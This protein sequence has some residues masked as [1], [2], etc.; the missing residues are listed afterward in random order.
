MMIHVFG[1]L[2]I[3]ICSGQLSSEQRAGLLERHN[4]YRRQE[5]QNNL[6]SG[7]IEM[8]WDYD[9]ETVAQTFA[10]QGT[11]AG[12][13]SNRTNHYEQLIG[14]NVNGVGEN[15]FSGPPTG[16]SG[17]MPE[18][19]VHAWVDFKWPAAWT[20]QPADCSERE[21]FYGECAGMTG[22][23]TQVLWEGSY[24]VGCG[25]T[26]TH[27]TTC[28]YFPPGNFNNLP[29]STSGPACA[30]CPSSHQNCPDSLCTMA[31]PTPSPTPSPTPPTSPLPPSVS[32][33]PS[34]ISSC[35]YS[36]IDWSTN[37]C[38]GGY[39]RTCDSRCF[40]PLNVI[41]SYY[42]PD[43]F[44]SQGHYDYLKAFGV[45]LNCPRFCCGL[46]W[47]SDP[48]GSDTAAL[49]GGEQEKKQLMRKVEPVY[50]ESESSAKNLCVYWSSFF[51]L[52]SVSCIFL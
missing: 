30:T 6:G 26:S 50:I 43:A 37:Q 24:K 1:F 23:F 21:A 45:N 22:H 32:P 20:G 10:N 9:L 38:P 27:G 19:A 4:F 48:C 13:N 16:G 14:E 18:D 8:E 36:T 25:Y 41:Q 52:L 11:F 44:G 3:R 47:E 28:N 51:M 33:T 40:S 29:H 42:N 31:P 39:V 2:F 12:H 17:S 46:E 15:W 5:A 35:T 49:G 34:P 7:M